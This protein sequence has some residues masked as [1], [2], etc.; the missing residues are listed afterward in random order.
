MHP[1]QNLRT[2]TQVHARNLDLGPKKDDEVSVSVTG[3][4]TVSSTVTVEG[5]E[6][7][8]EYLLLSRTRAEDEEAD[9]TEESPKACWDVF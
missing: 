8:P 3:D 4:N 6:A 1:H 2:R 5:V 9:E 7:Q